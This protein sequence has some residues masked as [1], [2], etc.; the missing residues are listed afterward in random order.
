MAHPVS[1]TTFTL[2]LTLILTLRAG[3]A[4]YSKEQRGPKGHGTYS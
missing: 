3:N 2:T 1:R 4:G